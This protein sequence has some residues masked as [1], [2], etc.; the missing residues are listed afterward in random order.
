MSKNLRD[1]A[2][3][4]LE[5]PNPESEIGRAQRE[6]DRAREIVAT[7]HRAVARSRELREEILRKRACRRDAL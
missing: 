7:A 1:A 3:P 2:P 4:S 6:I 5:W